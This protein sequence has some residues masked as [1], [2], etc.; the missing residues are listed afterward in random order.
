VHV[1]KL[2][3]GGKH[4]LQ[5]VGDDL[6]Q[7]KGIGRLKQFSVKTIFQCLLHQPVAYRIDII[8]STATQS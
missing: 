6:A 5:V 8:G 3:R 4:F 2:R 7:R 1:A